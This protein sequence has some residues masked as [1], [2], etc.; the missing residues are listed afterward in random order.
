MPPINLDKEVEIDRSIV[1]KDL[2]QRLG[3]GVSQLIS[4]LMMLGVMA[5]QNQE[6]TFEYAELV[7]SEFGRTVVL[8]R[9]ETTIE[10]G[11]RIRRYLRFGL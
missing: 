3:I 10:H 6:I 11:I 5:N 7:A 1:V 4:K 9:I 8:K 2:S